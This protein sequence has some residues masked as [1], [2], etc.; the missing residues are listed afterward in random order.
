MRTTT[1]AGRTW[2][3]S[4]YLGR[5][6]PEHNV[7]QFGSTGG[8]MYPMDVAFGDGDVLFAVS[9]G[10]GYGY[11][12]YIGDI[13]C[14]IGK[15]TIDEHHLGDFSRAGFTWPSG[16]AVAGDGKVY[17]S[18]EHECSISVFDPEATFPFPEGKPGEEALSTWG[19]KG[20]APGQLSGPSGIVFDSRDNLYV[21]DSRNDRVQLFTRDGQLLDGWGRSGAREGEFARPWGITIDTQGD[22]YVADWGNNRVQKFSGE[23]EYIQSFGVEYPE[24]MRLDHPSDVAV[25]SEGDVYVVDWGNK[26][27]QIF[28]SEGDILTCLYGDAVEF[29]KWAKE[30]VEANADALKAYRRVQDKSRLAAFERPTSIAIDQNDRIIISESTRGRLQVYVKE[31]E[32]MDPQYNL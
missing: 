10:M 25:D 30:V 2:H 9:R 21:V 11:D 1:V 17:C 24:E 18:D 26:R 22:V 8:Y 15:T 12:G 31:K 7:S 6:T 23:G 28:D 19:V 4:H 20:A 13:G 5:Q 14:R 16:L 27:V 29:S 32:Y 3:Y